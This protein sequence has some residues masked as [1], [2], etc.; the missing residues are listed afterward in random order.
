MIYLYKGKKC[1][2]YAQ[3][4]ILDSWEATEKGWIF[5]N[6]EGG[7]NHYKL[8][9]NA[10]AKPPS[11]I[12]HYICVYPGFKRNGLGSAGVMAILRHYRANGIGLSLLR[13]GT[14]D[15]DWYEGKIWRQKMY[16]KLGWI[17]LENHPDCTGD[18]PIMFHPMSGELFSPR[19]HEI[20]IEERS[21]GILSIPP[22]KLRNA[23]K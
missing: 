10:T 22:S 3:I 19:V 1:F 12:L 4:E 8:Q 14:Q 7:L 15:E 9:I 17:I 13:I 23:H 2:G 21:D 16:E 5:Q 6:L 11:L 20:R 18:V